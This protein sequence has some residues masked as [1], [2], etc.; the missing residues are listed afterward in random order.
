MRK[1]IILIIVTTLTI[2]LFG[3]TQKTFV[4]SFPNPTNSITVD[5]NGPVEIK[6]WNQPFV[7]VLTTVNIDNGNNN[8]LTELAKTGRY[9]LLTKQTESNT[10]VYTNEK[11][12]PLKYR[13]QT[14]TEK[15]EYTVF[16]PMYSKVKVVGKENPTQKNEL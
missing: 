3:Q 12:D 7:R 15:I 9:R 1:Y 2:N 11:H 16:V 10:T 5:L 13:G 14:I 4:K 6:E 8:V